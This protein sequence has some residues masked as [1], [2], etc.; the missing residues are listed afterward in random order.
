M[1]DLAAVY[2]RT[3]ETYLIVVVDNSAIWV[4]KSRF[5]C[6]VPFPASRTRSTLVIGLRNGTVEK[7]LMLRCVVRVGYNDLWVLILPANG[8]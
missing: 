6:S 5:V 8:A 4:P 1:L 7:P 3:V 2:V